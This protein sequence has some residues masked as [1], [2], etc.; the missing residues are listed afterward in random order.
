ML[1]LNFAH[2][3]TE[4]Q[5]QQLLAFLPAESLLDVQPVGSQ[6]DVTLPLGPQ[7][8]ALVDAVGLSATDW[9]RLPLV[10]IL[11]SL[12]FSTAVLLA[13]LYRRCGYFP[14]FVRL[15]SV[16]GALPPRFE[17]AEIVHLQEAL[18]DAAQFEL[19]GL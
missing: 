18:P 11:P 8:V 5:Q 19:E 10:L 9:Q 15:R 12:N 17:V 6:V 13:E 4:A 14:P 2:P 1:V 7:V 16:A 3:L